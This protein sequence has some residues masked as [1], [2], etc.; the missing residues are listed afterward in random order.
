MLG[1]FG[2]FVQSMSSLMRGTP[3]VTLWALMPARWKV[4]SVSCV[5]GSPM[6]V[7]ASGPMASPGATS[8]RSQMPCRYSKSASTCLT[9]LRARTR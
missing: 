8:A 9:E 4:L 3:S 2:F 1:V 6:E 7:E 5:S